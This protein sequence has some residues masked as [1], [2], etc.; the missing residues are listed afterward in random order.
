M[1]EISKKY[2]FYAAHR[3]KAAGEKCGRI[4]GH[5]YCVTF[6]FKFDTD[7]DIA[8]TFQDIDLRCEPVVKNLDHQFLVHMNDPISDWLL[9]AEEKFIMMYHPTSAENLA[10]YFYN[11]VKKDKALEA[12]YQVDVQETESAIVS[13]YEDGK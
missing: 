12:L 3:N 8:M 13:Y 10:R 4:H 6:R 11:K 2:K 1:I 9:K 7:D 5:T